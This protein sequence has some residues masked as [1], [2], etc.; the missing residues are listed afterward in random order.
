MLTRVLG[1][2]RQGT[3]APEWPPRALLDPI[4]DGVS[5][6]VLK[7]ATDIVAGV[8]GA[9]G[10]GWP[11]GQPPPKTPKAVATLTLEP[12]AYLVEVN[13]ADSPRARVWTHQA[14]ARRAWRKGP[15]GGDC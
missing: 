9:F 5:A 6:D 4:G 7:R 2:V 1:G 10:G 15:Q 12:G 3:Q 13:G 11:Q 14:W 8:L